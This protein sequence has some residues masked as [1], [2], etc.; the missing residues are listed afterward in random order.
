MSFISFH[1]AK[2]QILVSNLRQSKSD[3]FVPVLNG[4]QIL[5]EMIKFCGF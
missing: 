2:N 1:T 3:K 5:D 4:N